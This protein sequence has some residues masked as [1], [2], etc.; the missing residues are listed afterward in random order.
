MKA[1][2]SRLF[3]IAIAAL[4]AVFAS[5]SALAVDPPAPPKEE[6]AGQGWADGDAVGWASDPDR[7]GQIDKRDRRGS[8]WEHIFTG[9]T[10]TSFAWTNGTYDKDNLKKHPGYQEFNTPIENKGPDKLEILFIKPKDPDITDWTQTIQAERGGKS[11]VHGGNIKQGSPWSFRPLSELVGTNFLIPDLAPIQTDLTIYTAVNLDLYM[12]SNPL[13]FLGGNWQLG[14]TLDELGL[15]IVDGT[16]P[17]LEGIY[18]STSP[19]T[20]DPDSATGYV[21]AGGSAAWL[22]SDAF[23]DTH[24]DIGII[25]A[26]AS[27]IPEPSEWLLLCVGLSAMSVAVRRKARARAQDRAAA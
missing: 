23:Q 21:P 10:L 2:R 11:V 1:S 12:A 18:W 25:A 26:H 22:N 9:S 19:F 4:L 20:F 17:G 3:G 6:R 16:L 24:G 7:P 14:Q 15:H 5:Q 8:V 13:G 27:S